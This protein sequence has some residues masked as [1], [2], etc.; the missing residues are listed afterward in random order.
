MLAVYGAGG[1]ALQILNL[2]EAVAANGRN[3]SFVDDQRAGGELFG[4]PIRTLEELPDDAEF[5]VAVADPCA[6][7]SIVERLGRFA[8]LRAA[9]ALV[10][11]HA[12]V[13]EGTILCDH[14]TVEAGA[15]IGAHFHGNIYSYVA[16]ESVIGDCVTFAPRVSCNGRITIGDGAYV[17]TGAFLKQGIAIGAGAVIGMGSVVLED[18]PPGVTVV[19][20]PARIIR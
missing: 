9:T 2:V 13:A 19:G 15:R 3:V 10:S 1:F 8:T 12:S 4:H 11:P 17:G 7:R 14:T 20:N 6:R 5:V 18:V 16:H